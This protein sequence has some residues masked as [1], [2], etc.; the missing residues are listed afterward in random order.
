MQYTTSFKDLKAYWETSKKLA[1]RN[2]VRDVAL[3]LLSFKDKFGDAQKI[4]SRPRIQFLYIHHIFDDETRNFDRLLKA[5][6]KDH[7][8]I[9]HSEAVTR[10]LEGNVDKPYI[11]WSSDDGIKNNLTAARIL[12]EYGAKA[13]FFINPNSIGIKEVAKSKTFCEARLEMPPVEFLDWQD[14]DALLKDGHEIGAHTMDH[15]D[16]SDL[17]PKEFEKNLLECKEI[18]TEKCGEVHHFAYTYGK[19]SNFYKRAHELVFETGYDS[20]STA[21]R[22]CHIS[23]GSVIDKNDLLIRRDQIIGA[24]KLEHMLYFIKK[25]G[26]KATLENNVIPPEWL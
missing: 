26:L 5:L 21:V 10:L 11:A 3:D 24:W 22:G 18:L 25:S 9:T 17:D 1:M 19:Y 4:F 7:T 16:V 12:N 14:V 15:E 20:C 23:D 2:R 6:A 8:F 13:C